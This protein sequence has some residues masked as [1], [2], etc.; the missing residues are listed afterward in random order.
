MNPGRELDALVAEKVMGIKVRCDI[1][2][3]GTILPIV[4][5]T[6]TKHIE[7]YS[8][9]IAAAWEILSKFKKF[10]VFQGE[11]VMVEISIGKFGKESAHANTVPHA[12]CLA[13]L[14]VVG[15]ET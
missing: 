14:K 3:S 4:G 9:D 10:S 13:A 1:L 8:T 7:P 12:I 15:V 2:A 6:I 11:D 5:G